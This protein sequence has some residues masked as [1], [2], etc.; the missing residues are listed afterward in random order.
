LAGHI[1]DRAG[2]PFE[3]VLPGRPARAE[4]GSHHVVAFERD[5]RA[6]A[7]ADVDVRLQREH[8]DRRVRLVAAERRGV[9]AQQPTDLRGCH[10]E[11]LRRRGAARDERCDSA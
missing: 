7:D 8:G 2:G 9:R 5:A 4:H 10:G 6:D 1:G 11:Y 3:A